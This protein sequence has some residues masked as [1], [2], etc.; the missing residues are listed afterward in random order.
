MPP[1]GIS[2]ITESAVSLI[3]IA[4]LVFLVY[5]FTRKFKSKNTSLDALVELNDDTNQVK[6]K[7]TENTYEGLREMAFSVTP[8]QLGIKI[9]EG[10]QTVYGVI[11][12][13]EMGGAISSTIAYLSG[14]ASMYLSTGGG[15]I[16]GGHH[17]NVNAAV[18]T[19][20]NRATDAL[21]YAKLTKEHSLPELNSV[22]FYLL[23]VNGIYVA[24][25]SMESFE[26][27][28][29]PLLGLFEEGNKVLTELRMISEK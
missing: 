24:Q 13:W 12:D 17:K 14:D 8:D 29:S 10:Q 11:M 2:E 27:G 18:R 15:I 5:L 4:G 25:E 22:K 6:H 3:L 7:P 1:L 20:V 26:N 19:F 16:G 21:R 28:S 9:S 23:T